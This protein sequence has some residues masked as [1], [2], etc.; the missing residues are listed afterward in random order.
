MT[1]T[2]QVFVP[3]Y[4]RYLM[5]QPP[6]IHYQTSN[7][8][9]EQKAWERKTVSGMSTAEQMKGSFGIVKSTKRRKNR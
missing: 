6:Q 2:G 8:P 9:A 3:Q 5:N 4:V 1:N 7:Q